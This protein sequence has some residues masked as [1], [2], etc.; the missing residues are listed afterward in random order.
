MVG[1]SSQTWTR[2]TTF[3]FNAED[4]LLSS[5]SPHYSRFVI[6]IICHQCWIHLSTLFECAGP[7]QFNLSAKALP[8]TCAQAAQPQVHGHVWCA[9]MTGLWSI[10]K[11]AIH[12]MVSRSGRGGQMR[13]GVVWYC[14]N[15]SIL[16][17]NFGALEGVKSPLIQNLSTCRTL[18]VPHVICL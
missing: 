17:D 2:P 12:R 6:I 13:S 15:L 10:D 5:K 9:C 16:N 8:H 1:L 7:L 4:C 18:M 14:G 3:N 11:G